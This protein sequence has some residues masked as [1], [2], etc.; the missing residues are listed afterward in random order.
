MPDLAGVKLTDNMINLK[1]SIVYVDSD[2][3]GQKDDVQLGVWFD[4]KMYK[5][6]YF[7]LTDFASQMGSLL[8]IYSPTK[9]LNIEV[10][11]EDVDNS[12][13]LSIFYFDENWKTF[14]TTTGKPRA[15]YTNLKNIGNYK[16]ENV[17]TTISETSPQT[18][19]D[20]KVGAFSLL[21]GTSALAVV[22]MEIKCYSKK[23]V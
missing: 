2:K 7:Y 4:N 10:S 17:K 6:E 3:D 23:R 11:T 1:L 16:V 14:L 12:A 15:V 20:S 8:G 22:I 19:D 9:G 13:D 5:N 21:L 18:G